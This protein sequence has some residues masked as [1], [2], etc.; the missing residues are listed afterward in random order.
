MLLLQSKISP[1]PCSR[2][3][4]IAAAKHKMVRQSLVLICIKADEL[5][6]LGQRGE[7]LGEEAARRALL[8]CCAARPKVACVI[9]TSGSCAEITRRSYAGFC[10]FGLKRGLG[11]A[12]E[13]N[14]DK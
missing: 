6:H 1:V 9:Q 10:I 2:R 13:A 4:S 14:K 12:G 11:S 7:Q 3:A 5:R 8:H